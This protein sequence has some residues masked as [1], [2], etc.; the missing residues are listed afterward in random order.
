MKRL[1][2]AFNFQRCLLR[3]QK[4]LT[5]FRLSRNGVMMQKN[6]FGLGIDGESG[7]SVSQSVSQSKWQRGDFSLQRYFDWMSLKIYSLKF[8]RLIEF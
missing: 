6:T 4:I 2:E 1:N 3:Q 7:W 8:I 5:L